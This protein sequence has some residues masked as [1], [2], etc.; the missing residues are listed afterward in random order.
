M[1]SRSFINRGEPAQDG[2]LCGL[3]DLAFVGRVVLRRPLFEG[4]GTILE[5][6]FPREAG[7]NAGSKGGE[8]FLN[9]QRKVWNKEMRKLMVIEGSKR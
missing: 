6:T 5:G 7:R 1:A 9:E 4:G 8:Y 3:V 2:G